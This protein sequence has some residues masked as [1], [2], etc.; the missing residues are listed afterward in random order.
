MKSILAHRN[1]MFKPNKKPHIR[2]GEYLGLDECPYM[3][4]WVL[5]AGF[6]SLR[7]HHFYRSDDKRATHDHPFW[8]LTLILKGGYVD[9]TYNERGEAQCQFMRPGRIALRPA[10]H[11][12]SVVVG[13]GYGGC[14]TFVLTGPSKRKWGFF[15]RENGEEHRFVGVR[16]YF[17]QFG[18]PPCDEP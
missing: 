4:R 2:W 16:Q 17:K 18:H 3:R 8:F 11:K 5:S 9:I 12:H 10:N 14:W 1:F 13:Q 6:F 15:L 7:V